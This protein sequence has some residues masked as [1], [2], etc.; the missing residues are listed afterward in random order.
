MRLALYQPDIPQNAGAMLRLAACF[1][2][3]VDFIL[4]AGFVL[5][6][7]RMRRAGMDY[8]DH[9]EIARHSSWSA[10]REARR[11]DEGRLLLLTTQ[12]DTPYTDFTFEAEDTLL[13]GRES[14][15]VPIDVHDA[16]D[17]RLVIPMQPGLRSLNV[18]MAAAI[19]AGEA[20]RQIKAA[21]KQERRA[22]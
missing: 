20:M 7:A 8:I 17:A 4:P 1:G 21:G 6:D 9:V 14:G 16:A 13:V 5:D 2:L 11:H 19:V 12:G 22:S 15:G 3:G 10:Y 18:A